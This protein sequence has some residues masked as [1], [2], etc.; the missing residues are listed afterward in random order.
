VTLP[1][2]VSVAR[3]LKKLFPDFP[4]ELLTEDELEA[5]LLE[6]LGA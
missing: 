4:T 5:E 6:R 1:E 3:E 2:P